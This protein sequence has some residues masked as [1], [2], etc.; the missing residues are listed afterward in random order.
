MKINKLIAV[1]LMLPLLA[2]CA[3][4]AG[5]KQ[6]LGTL[7]GAAGGGLAGAQIGKGKGQLAATAAGALIGALVGSEV[8]KSLDQADRM[9]MSQNRQNALETKKTGSRSTWTNP[10]SGHSGTVTPQ[11]AIEQS[12]GTYCREFQET[13]TISGQEET[14]YGTACRQADGTWK[15]IN[16]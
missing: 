1:G 3:Q 14:A 6:S 2:S 8:G 11:P 4:G 9:Y 16:T 15:I 7:I 13:V 12:N 5:D 10:D